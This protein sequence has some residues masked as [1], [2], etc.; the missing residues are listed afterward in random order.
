MNEET[1]KYGIRPVSPPLTP[2][3][4]MSLESDEDCLEVMVKWGDHQVLQVTHVPLDGS[5]VIGED[6]EGQV[7][8]LAGAETLGFGRLS[9]V[10]GGRLMAPAAA[11]ILVARDG[12]LTDEAPS[13][14]PGETCTV[15]IG[16]LHFVVR[17]VR[18]GKKTKRRAIAVERQPLFF[19]GGAMAVAGFLLALFALMPPAGAALASS[20]I[21]TDSRLVE[22]LMEPQVTETVELP[23][24]SAV[25]DPGGTE[26]QAH[27]GDEGEMGDTE[28][29]RADAAYAV[30]GPADNEDPH[31]ARE[32]QMEE[33][34]TAGILGTIASFNGS[35]NQP[36]SPFGRENALG[37]DTDSFLGNL[38]GANIGNAGG[39]GGLGLHGTGR[40][41]G[42]NGDGTVGAGQYGTLGHGCRGG[43]CGEGTRYGSGVGGEMSRQGRTPP[44]MSIGQVEAIG[45]LSKEAIRRV[46]NRH[47]N[48]VKFCYEQALQSRPD[49]AGRV[50]MRFMIAPSGAVQ[51]AG[52]QSS[53]LGNQGV[54]SCVT[55]AVRRWS[56]PQPE[57]GGSV[58]VTYPFSLIPAH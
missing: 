19:V 25:E 58:M 10:D 36:T 52:V 16:E 34:R 15:E 39:A 8:F 24:S 47:R 48:E 27:S 46:I 51:V 13:L 18:A 41:A 14:V 55:T 11:T 45:T 29:P 9:L 57:G 42:G 20:G 7:D 22:F 1:T 12:E 30:E 37:T 56:F 17:R 53:S 50:T 31:L 21:D 44:S 43:R 40:G 28:A 33:A 38:M 3:D 23:D 6:G 49:L 54:E 5:F 35:F 4:A 32:R 26:G 2:A